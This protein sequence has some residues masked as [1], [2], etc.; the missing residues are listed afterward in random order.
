M[1]RIPRIVVGFALIV[2]AVING[3]IWFF[4]GVIPFVTGLMNICP[5]E[6]FL[7]GCKDGKC[8]TTLNSSCG[9][10]NEIDEK[11]KENKCCDAETS[12]SVNVSI[13]KIEI[14]GTGCANCKALYEV[15]LNV[16]K[17]MKQE[18]EIIKV[19]DLEEIIKY[20]VV[21]TPALVINGE[22]KSTGRLLN[23]QAMKEIIEQ[24]I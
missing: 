5:L 18:F 13:V 15:A 12:C 23:T 24:T 11:N 17:D 14:L 6:K 7:G 1:C 3:N 21:S 19:E 10:N 2:Y 20:S 9:T 22:V 16:T 4:L 8:D